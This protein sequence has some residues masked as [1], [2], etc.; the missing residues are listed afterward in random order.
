MAHEHMSN[1]GD[2]SWRDPDFGQA[3]FELKQSMSTWCYA[4]S[5]GDAQYTGLERRWWRDKDT[6]EYS[7][8]ELVEGVVSHTVFLYDVD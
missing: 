2:D 5:R 7:K 6:G 3:L 1:R 8:G 4:N